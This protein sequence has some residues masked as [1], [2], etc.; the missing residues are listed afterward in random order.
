M[1]TRVLKTAANK[2][3]GA[4]NLQ[5]VRKKVISKDFVANY[6]Q[7]L[8]L[9]R[10]NCPPEFTFSEFMVCETGGHSR[11]YVDAECEF[12][13]KHVNKLKPK[14]ILDIGSYRLFIIGLLA[15]YRLTTVDVRNRENNIETEAVIVCD[16]K[17]LELPSNEFDLV[18]SLCAL[19]HFGLGRYGDEFDLD[20][21]RKAFNEMVRVIIPKG[22]LIFSTAIT[23]AEPTIL[24]NAHRIYSY[25]MIKRFCRG[26]TLIE[27]KIY[28]RT[29][30]HLISMEQVT[31]EPNVYDIYC[32]CWQK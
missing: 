24:F 6:K 20:A 4:F 1:F 15:H 9:L 31:R 32:G 29:E 19:E 2:T 12:V 11:S 22:Y 17:N 18:I 16:A 5:L 28:N 21:D 10:Q 14:K 23:N 26:L 7:G 3:L 27:E 25:E 30:G 8:S 13:A